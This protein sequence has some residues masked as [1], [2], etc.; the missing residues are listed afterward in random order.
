MT[1]VELDLYA[2]VK[3]V[4]R[5]FLGD[6]RVKAVDLLVS[7]MPD[8]PRTVL[9]DPDGLRAVLVELLTNAVK[10]T[11]HGSV[12]LHVAVFGDAGGLPEL[13]FSVRDTG[14]GMSRMAQERLFGFGDRV[15]ALSADSDGVETGL[16]K[17]HR[18]VAAMG[19]RV[20]IES[21][22]GLGSTV[23][24]AVALEKPASA[25]VGPGEGM[26]RAGP[27]ML[28]G[29]SDTEVDSLASVIRGWGG[30]P[31]A[32]ARVPLAVDHLNGAGRPLEFH[33][34]VIRAGKYDQAREALSA[35]SSLRRP[36][37]PLV[38]CVVRRSGVVE[39]VPADL[40][41][42]FVSVV[43]VP[44]TTASLF[45]ALHLVSHMRDGSGRVGVVALRRYFGAR[46][47]ADRSAFAIVDSVAVINRRTLELAGEVVRDGGGVTRLVKEFVRGHQASCQ[48]LKIAVEAGDWVE[49]RRLLDSIM[50]GSGGVGAERLA[51]LCERVLALSDDDLEAAG[52][53]SVPVAEEFMAVERALRD[54]CPDGCGAGS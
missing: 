42:A 37:P 21:A 14:V 48:R 18:L 31:V 27:V 22:P 9:G 41:A 40:A 38:L 4:A 12:A 35:L 7:I 44:V 43:Y 19:G 6:A 5:A 26:F 49:T 15:A 54:L 30:H 25:G 29:F 52:D 34:V 36:V 46:G 23:W 2:L 16:A 8:V 3:G 13:K 28:V 10:F 39:A 11:S 24:F 47:A 1:K 53:L 33:S 51:Y 50:V 17:V 32:V 20:G 45:N